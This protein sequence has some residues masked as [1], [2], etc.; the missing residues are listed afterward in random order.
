[1]SLDRRELADNPV[2]AF[3]A[4][5]DG[6]QATVWTALPGILISFDPVK[7]TAQVQTAIQMQETLKD[8]T[9][10]W[11]TITP[12]VDCPVIFPSGGGLILTFPLEVGDE[13]LVIFSARCIDN[14]WLNGGVQTQAQLRMHDLSD[15][16]CL[17]GPKSVPNA[18]P[19]NM[20]AA[21]LR[22][23]DGAAKVRLT[24]TGDIE[25]ITPG[26]ALVQAGTA[27]VTAS[28]ISLI[29][30]V[31]IT[32]SFTV[33]GVDIGENHT[34]SGIEPGPSNTGGVVP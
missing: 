24:K 33:N 12:L 30:D 18:T 17:P 29:G 21:E 31:S 3:L 6:R 13:V 26:T 8:G 28:S 10:R 7:Q 1:M 22:T 34:H 5:L 9:T 25:A 15:G 2:T 20:A 16:F 23:N 32:G 11:I 14:W 27:E 19:V 4:A